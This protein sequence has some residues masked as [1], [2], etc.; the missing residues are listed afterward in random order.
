M[1]EDVLPVEAQATLRIPREAARVMQAVIPKSLN[2]PVGLLPWCLMVKCTGPAHQP[3][4]RV[5][6]KGVEPSESEIIR[7]PGSM[8]GINSRNRHTPL[9]SMGSPLNRR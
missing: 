2:D 3:V 7:W 1:E 6:T 5:P 8:K 9:R 4:R